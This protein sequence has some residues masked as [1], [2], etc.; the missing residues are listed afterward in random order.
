MN[1][2]LQKLKAERDD[3]K[4]RFE[5]LKIKQDIGG[6]ID[7]LPPR[8][9]RS[10]VKAMVDDSLEVF[11]LDSRENI[12]TRSGRPARE[13]IQA[14]AD[15]YNFMTAAP[16]S[17]KQQSEDQDYRFTGGVNIVDPEIMG[18]LT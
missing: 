14:R 4:S 17:T 2:D 5:E 9:D 13:W 11:T 7:S 12:V 18:K 1:E 10:R 15:L 16:V 6:I 3:Y 8:Y